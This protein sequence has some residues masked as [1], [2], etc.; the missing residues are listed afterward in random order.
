MQCFTRLYVTH[1]ELRESF[2][3]GILK[4]HDFFIDFFDQSSLILHNL[5]NDVTVLV[6][7]D[8]F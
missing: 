8:I 2:V 7:F 6:V 4:K 3:H 1:G 5:K